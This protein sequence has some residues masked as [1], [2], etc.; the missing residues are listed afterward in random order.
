[1]SAPESKCGQMVS[2]QAG[3]KRSVSQFIRPGGVPTLRHFSPD[4][5]PAR[6]KLRDCASRDRW[7]Y[8]HIHANDGCA[9]LVSFIRLCAGVLACTQLCKASCVA[10][11]FL[12]ACACSVGPTNFAQTRAALVVQGVVAMPLAPQRGLSRAQQRSAKCL[13]STSGRDPEIRVC[14]NRT[15]KKQGSTKVRTSAA[16]MIACLAALRPETALELQHHQCCIRHVP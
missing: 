15:C 13:A 7:P 11:Q 16:R 8:P 10:L 5:I 3:G 9:K 4:V 2:A 1:M 6:A 14:T 12:P